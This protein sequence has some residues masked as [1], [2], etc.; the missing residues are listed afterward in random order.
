MEIYLIRKDVDLFPLLPR[1]ELSGELELDS[2][3]RRGGRGP[4]A[5][6]KLAAGEQPAPVLRVSWKW[7]TVHYC[8]LIPYTSDN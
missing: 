4:V 8:D 5:D 7:D 1:H 6:A 2:R 3:A